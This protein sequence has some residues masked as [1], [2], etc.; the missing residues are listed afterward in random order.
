MGFSTENLLV[1]RVESASGVRAS[2]VLDYINGVTGHGSVSMST[3]TPLIGRDPALHSVSLG[4]SAAAGINVEVPRVDPTFFSTLGVPIRAGR[5]FSTADTTA[6]PTVA[7]VNETLARRLWPDGSPLG[8][9]IQLDDRAHDVIGVVADYLYAPVS[10]ATP[11]VFLPLSTAAGDTRLTFVLRTP[12]AAGPFIEQLRRNIPK[13]ANDHMVASA[14][15]ANE[16]IALG[17]LEILAGTAPLV[18]LITIGLLLTVSGVY[19]VLAFAVARRSKEFALRTAL[20]A[21]GRDIVRLV[22]T[23][24]LRLIVIGSLFGMAL[25]FALTRV[26]RASGGAGS[27]FDTPGWPAFAVPMVTMLGVGAIATW[28]PSLRALRAHPATLLRVD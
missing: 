26:V 7:I 15:A 17:G 20:G 10:L 24:S 23:Q 5:P 21:S 9:R 19:A 13:V 6:L 25:T 8:T 11:S 28:I 27:M 22:T 14:V 1:V 18:P 16:W 4:A 2:T 12:T 3:S